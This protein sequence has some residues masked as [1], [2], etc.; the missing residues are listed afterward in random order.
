MNRIGER[1][2][3]KREQ[4]GLQ[5]N[6]LAQKVGITSSALSQIEKSKSYP[7]VVTLKL[8]AENLQTT[9]GEL[10]GENESIDNHPVLRNEESVFVAE[11]ESGAE[12]YLLSQ[13]DLSRQ[14]DTFLI[15][16][17][18]DSNS[19]GLFRQHTSHV[20]GYLLSGELQ[21]NINNESYVVKQGDSIY[22]NG[23][24]NFKLQNLSQAES[25]LLCV[26]LATAK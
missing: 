19:I 24:Q 11:N 18:P 5:L 26:S 23:K 12:L 16:F 15:K 17:H 22:F 9:V 6:E 1:I 3:H 13:Q 21:F 20:F 14:M 10:M 8:I 4:Y 2:K 7:S 25:K